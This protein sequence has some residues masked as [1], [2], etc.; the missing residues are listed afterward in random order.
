MLDRVEGAKAADV[1]KA[2]R[3]YA[4]QKTN[5]SRTTSPRYLSFETNVVSFPRLICTVRCRNVLTN[6]KFNF[7][8]IVD[9]KI[10]NCEKSSDQINLPRYKGRFLSLIDKCI[11]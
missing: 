11:K 1:T 6:F 4:A 7:T 3:K 8:Q 2:V 5:P 10:M 9:G